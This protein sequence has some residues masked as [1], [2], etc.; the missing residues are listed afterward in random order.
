[1]SSNP[2]PPLHLS[3][4]LP[5]LLIESVSVNIQRSGHLGVPQQPGHRGNI[6][7]AGDHQAGC[8]VPQAVDVQVQGKAVLFE[9]QFEPPGECSCAIK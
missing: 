8:R 3:T 7:P 4:D 9:N 6:R 1:M 2:H 5:L